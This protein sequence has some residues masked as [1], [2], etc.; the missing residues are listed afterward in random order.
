MDGENDAIW[1]PDHSTVS[2]QNGGQT[3]PCGFS[4]DWNDFQSFHA[5][6][7]SFNSAE[8]PLKF[9]KKEKRYFKASDFASFGKNEHKTT[10]SKPAP[11]LRVWLLSSCSWHRLEG[12]YQRTLNHN[13]TQQQRIKNGVNFAGRYIEMRMRRVQLSM[14][15]ESKK[16]VFKTDTAL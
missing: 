16:S 14:R 9:H 5:L 2:I 13:N 8:A 4:L 15:T 7:G 1:A 6:A 12:K 3:L 11:C 10:L